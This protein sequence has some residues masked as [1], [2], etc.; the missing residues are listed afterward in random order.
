[1]RIGLFPLWSDGQIGG[2]TTYDTRL[3]PALAAAAPAVDF[4]IYTPSP[5]AIRRFG[6]PAANVTHHRLFPRSRCS[7]SVPAPR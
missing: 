6:P 3:P 5:D 1:M 4:H 2:I 7:T